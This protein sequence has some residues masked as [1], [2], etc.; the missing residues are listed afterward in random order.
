MMAMISVALALALSQPGPRA[1]A[2]IG[3]IGSRAFVLKSV[4]VDL[5]P[6]NRSELR[7][8]MCRRSAGASLRRLAVV[9]EDASGAPIWKGVVATPSFAPG[10]MH[11]CR[12]LKIDLP[13]EIARKAMRWRLERP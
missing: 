8:W 11:E 2:V 3:E 12:V 9:A 5:H 7:G 4:R 10:L 13:S 1:D 6:D